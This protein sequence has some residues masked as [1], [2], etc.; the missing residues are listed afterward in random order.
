M[1]DRKPKPLVLVFR[2]GAGDWHYVCSRCHAGGWDRIWSAALDR[3]IKHSREH[4][5]VGFSPP[6]G[7][8]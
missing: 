4:D 7:G 8:R 3:G 6:K 2:Q 5:Q 1:A